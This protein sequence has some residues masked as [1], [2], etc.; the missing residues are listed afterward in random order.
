MAAKDNMKEEIETMRRHFGGLVALVKYLKVRSATLE[1][2]KDKSDK[3][4][5]YP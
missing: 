5:N 4:Q 3:I 2:E 1:K